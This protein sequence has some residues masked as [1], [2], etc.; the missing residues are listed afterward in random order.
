[1]AIF[2]SYVSLPE[3]KY[4]VINPS[5]PSFFAPQQP[6]NSPRPRLARPNPLPGCGAR[7]WHRALARNAPGAPSFDGF[8]WIDSANYLILTLILM[9]ILILMMM[10]LILMTMMMMVMMTMMMMMMMM[11]M[12]MMTEKSSYMM[13]KSPF[14]SPLFPV[15]MVKSHISI[16][17][18]Q[19]FLGSIP[20]L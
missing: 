18:H 7:A 17:F 5:T 13:V 19:F 15:L 6:S 8:N 1:M 3:G 12:T 4:S 14:S 20:K 11:T 16:I 2:N 9:M 10:I